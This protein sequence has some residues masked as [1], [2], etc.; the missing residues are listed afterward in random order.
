M[1]QQNPQQPAPPPNAHEKIEKNIGLMAVLIA[2][3]VS[4]GGLAEIVPLMFQAETIQPLPG[5][6]PYDALQLAAIVQSSDDA[7][8]GKDLNSIVTSWNTAAERMFGYSAAEIVGRSVRLIIPHDR[9][10]EEDDVLQRIRSGRRLEHYETIRRRK[11][12]VMIPVSL[13]ISPICDERGVVIGASKIARDI[14]ERVRADEERERLLE[15]ARSA[16]RLKDEFLATLSH[17]LRTPLNAI[18]G[19]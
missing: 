4:F 2:I 19:Y 18:V 12:G 11:D 10:H 3:A 8:V 16:N 1:D 17:E 14:S 7:I 5:V 6:K 15:I 9:Q 13:T